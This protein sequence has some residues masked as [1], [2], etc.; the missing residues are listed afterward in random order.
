MRGGDW[1]LA[2]T[3]VV[4]SISDPPIP[5]CSTIAAPILD[6]SRLRDGAPGQGQANEAS[7]RIE[8]LVIAEDAPL[9][10]RNAPV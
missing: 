10:E 4:P 6:R 9:V 2:A 3:R 1:R 5:Q 7:L 8:L